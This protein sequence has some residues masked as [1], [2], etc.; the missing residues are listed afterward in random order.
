MSEASMKKISA[1]PSWLG[2]TEDRRK[3][4]F[5]PERA[6]VVRKIFELAIGGIGSYAIA[7]HL[8]RER[9]PAF[10]PSQTWDHTTVDSMLRNRAT[11]GEYQPKSYAGGS[12]KGVPV[13]P[14]VAGYYP[15]AI[16]EATFHAAQAAR[17]QNLISGRGRKG[18][19]IAN[20]FSGLA[21]CAYCGS[22]IKFHSNGD[23]KSLICSKVLNN[24]GCIRTAWSYRDFEGNVLCFL[25]HPALAEKL[26]FGQKKIMSDLVYLIRQLSGHEV[27]TA[28]FNIALLLKEIIS[29]LS[30]SSAGSEPAQRLSEAL[31]RR[32]ISGRFFEIRLWDGPL[33]KGISVG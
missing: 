32:D 23:A 12:K 21:I 3:F 22:E 5:L 30:I 6:E 29:E 14:P 10:G 19:N 24:D 25:A 16:D 2:L 33:Y 8:N 27:Y 15:A 4:V 1:C 9:I 17:R 31:V 28:R 26:S 11:F 20:I 13:G 18:N 7:N